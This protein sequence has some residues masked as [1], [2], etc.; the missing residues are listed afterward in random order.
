[1]RR[2]VRLGHL[3]DR[4]RILYDRYFVLEFELYAT[5]FVF[6]DGFRIWGQ[7]FVFGA[8][9]FDNADGRKEASDVGKK[10]KVRRKSMR[11][12]AGVLKFVCYRITWRGKHVHLSKTDCCGKE[13][14]DIFCLLVPLPSIF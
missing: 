12:M 6:G 2:S 3:R 5:A 9:G 14:T 7:G 4:L 8:G 10:T 13:S 11:V 1:M